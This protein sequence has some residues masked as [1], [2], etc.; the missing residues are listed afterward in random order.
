MVIDLGLD[1]S[2]EDVLALRTDQH[3]QDS[4]LRSGDSAPAEISSAEACRAYL[5]CYYLS[6]T[7]ILPSPSDTFYRLI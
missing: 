3:L 1:Q 7:Y 6:A 4:S 5:G 2:M